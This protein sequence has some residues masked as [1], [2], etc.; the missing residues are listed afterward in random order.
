MATLISLAL[1]KK[2]TLIKVFIEQINYPY[3][4]VFRHLWAGF[5]DFSLRS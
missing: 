2:K 4:N 1:K 5:L 3:C